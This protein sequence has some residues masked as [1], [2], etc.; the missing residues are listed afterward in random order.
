MSDSDDEGEGQ[1]D[2]PSSSSDEEREP[3]PIDIDNFNAFLPRLDEIPT[4]D[5]AMIYETLLELDK[6]NRRVI[7]TRLNPLLV[8]GLLSREPQSRSAVRATLFM[9]NLVLCAADDRWAPLHLYAM[10]LIPGAIY[11]EDLV[12]S[13][14]LYEYASAIAPRVVLDFAESAVMC[15]KEL[16]PLIIQVASYVAPV[17]FQLYMAFREFRRASITEAKEL[18]G[19]LIKN[20]DVRRI[21][22]LITKIFVDYYEDNHTID[23]ISH[24]LF[25][26]YIDQKV[27]FTENLPL[28]GKVCQFA[29]LACLGMSENELTRDSDQAYGLLRLLHRLSMI[30]DRNI[31]EWDWIAGSRALRDF[32]ES[33]I[34]AGYDARRTIMARSTGSNYNPVYPWP[35]GDSPASHVELL[36]IVYAFKRN[37]DCWTGGPNT[38][39]FF[40]YHDVADPSIIMRHLLASFAS[41]L[42]EDVC[43]QL[44]Y[45]GGDISVL[46]PLDDVICVAVGFDKEGFDIRSDADVQSLARKPQV[47]AE[48][49]EWV[50]VTP[51]QT[52]H[53]IWLPLVTSDYNYRSGGGHRKQPS[54]YAD[55][56]RRLLVGNVNEAERRR[57]PPRPFISRE[58]KRRLERLGELGQIELFEA[59]RIRANIRT[60]IL[61]SLSGDVL[62]SIRPDGQVH[63][64]INEHKNLI[65]ADI[66]FLSG[67]VQGL[68]HL[69]TA[70]RCM[71]HFTNNQWVDSL[72][73]PPDT[74]LIQL[75]EDV[76]AAWHVI[77]AYRG[78]SVLMRYA[79]RDNPGKFIEVFLQR[80]I[81]RLT[82]GN[83]LI[84]E[85]PLSLQA[86]ILDEKYL[87]HLGWIYAYILVRRVSFPYFGPVIPLGEGF[88]RLLITKQLLGEYAI[89][90][91]GVKLILDLDTLLSVVTFD[92]LW[93]RMQARRA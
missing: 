21:P 34:G 89:F 54:F 33:M 19:T 36:P 29:V 57:R 22:K 62:D 24:L 2:F 38:R 69:F 28:A 3:S 71:E 14:A 77:T 63:T 65:D 39:F 88:L 80:V 51:N 4:G 52:R 16:A 66:R 83:P 1:E 10:K 75:D 47:F 32:W 81:A 27:L 50:A 64:F 56:D 23:P 12:I 67:V 43:H 30:L 82:G 86:Q 6:F 44:R 45:R 53:S 73:E 31:A 74:Y 72:V 41:V 76:D 79:V 91:E 55:L 92:E 11:G 8:V 20:R 46:G 25:A 9:I 5:T 58:C 49:N 84:G 26:G 42:I 35:F 93:C 85:D 17:A 78:E 48:L 18:T 59:E 40:E 87:A 70:F 61:G 60:A 68:T 7:V 90:N 13:Y 37:L 15:M